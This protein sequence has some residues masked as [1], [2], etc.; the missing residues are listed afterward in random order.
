VLAFFA[1]VLPHVVSGVGAA[2][3]STFWAFGQI[4]SSH[5]YGQGLPVA[6]TLGV[7]LSFYAVVP[8][9]AFAIRSR[10]R[11]EPYLLV[12]LWIGS[13]LVRIASPHGVVGGTLVGYLGWFALGMGLARLA[14]SPP[15]LPI[16]PPLIWAVAAS[17]FLLLAGRLPIARPNQ[18]VLLDYIGLGLLALLV[19]L[20]AVTHPAGARLKWLGDRSYGVYLWHF[21][22]L[23]WLASQR[24]SLIE[25]VVLGVG[26]T[27]AAADFSYRYLEAPLMLRAAAL[28]DHRRHRA[29]APRRAAV[30]RPAPE[31]V[32]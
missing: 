2:G 4:Y 24:I 20:P 26:L 14:Q 27:L 9:F 32:V 8:V 30:P 22:T 1:V 21:P 12:G 31:L 23:A 3:G 5:T 10:D 7:E 16:R 15:T 11:L 28:A 17:G 29:A 25:Y 13:L 19:V 18:G 6:W